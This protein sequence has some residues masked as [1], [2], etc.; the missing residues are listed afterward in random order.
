VRGNELELAASVG[1]VLGHT[2]Q[3]THMALE[4]LARR[5]ERLGKW[6]LAVELLRTVPDSELLLAKCCAR[7]AASLAEIDDLHKQV[8]TLRSGVVKIQLTLTLVQTYPHKVL[9]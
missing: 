2:P 8:P 6:E 5:C 3:L 1:T 7:C 4:L 9:P